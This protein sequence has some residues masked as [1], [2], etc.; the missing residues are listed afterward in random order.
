MPLVNNKILVSSDREAPSSYAFRVSG[1]LVRC[2][3]WAESD[4]SR[5]DNRDDTGY[6]KLGV[7]ARDERQDNDDFAMIRAVVQNGL[8][9]PLYPMPADSIEGR[10]VLV[11][12][13]ESDTTDDLAAWYEELQL[14]GPARLI[15]ANENRFGRPWPRPTLKLRS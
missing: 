3:F 4:S 15:R 1:R 8:I 14:L 2:G 6:D 11:E 9:R 5:W 10:V 12:D 13:A 7:G